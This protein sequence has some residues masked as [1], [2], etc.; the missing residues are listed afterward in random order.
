LAYSA[1]L[2]NDELVSFDVDSHGQVRVESFYDVTECFRGSVFAKEFY[3]D[4]MIG[5]VICFDKVHEGDER[6]E[7]VLVM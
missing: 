4:L 7:I 3:K 2:G 1:S 5:C 6:L